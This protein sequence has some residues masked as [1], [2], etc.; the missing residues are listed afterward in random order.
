MCSSPTPDYWGILA[1][2]EKDK[3]RDLDLRYM[4]GPY[5]GRQFFE[6]PVFALSW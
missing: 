5:I 3:F 6:A 2:A 4:V 1:A